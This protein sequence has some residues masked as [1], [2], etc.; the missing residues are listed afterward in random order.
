MKMR[1]GKHSENYW[2][3]K[4]WSF[5]AQCIADV[6]T[7]LRCIVIDRLLENY[8]RGGSEACSMQ[9]RRKIFT[10]WK[11]IKTDIILQRILELPGRVRRHRSSG[12]PP[13]HYRSTRGYEQVD[14]QTCS[15]KNATGAIKSSNRVAISTMTTEED[16]ESSDSD[17]Q[18]GT[19]K[20]TSDN[21]G[22]KEA[23]Y[24]FTIPH[25]MKK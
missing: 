13:H 18:R 6:R 16:S 8:M 10:T 23:H 17:K 3:R 14:A 15:A 19:K 5:Q 7:D 11:G 22:S 21:E 25:T 4:C 2:L 12:T 1:K 24:V 9:L 20:T